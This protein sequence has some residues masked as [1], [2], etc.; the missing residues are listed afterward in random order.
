M[1]SMLFSLLII[2][3]GAVQLFAQANNTSAQKDTLKVPPKENLSEAAKDSIKEVKL[4]A[5]M[6]YPL[7]KSSKAAGVLPVPD[8]E[9]KQDPGMQYKLIFA[10]A[11][12][13]KDKMYNLNDGLN[14]VARTINLHAAAGIPATHIHAVVILFKQGLNLLLKDELYKAKYNSPNPNIALIEELQK[15]G[16]TFITCGQSMYRTGIKKETFIPGVKVSLSART[17][18]S[19]YGTMGYIEQ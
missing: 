4:Q 19:Y 5:V 2:L 7:I 1:K 16:V 8:I 14:E 9:E 11:S 10:V 3:S 12:I 13:E 6:T 18:F 15:A 17:A